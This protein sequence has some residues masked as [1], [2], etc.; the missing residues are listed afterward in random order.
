MPAANLQLRLV[1][2][3]VGE[4]VLLPVLWRKEQTKKKRVERLVV[5]DYM[6]FANSYR[7]TALIIILIA[8]KQVC[9]QC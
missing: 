7:E 1:G 4:V 8:D 5:K 2:I 3:V 9:S 6:N